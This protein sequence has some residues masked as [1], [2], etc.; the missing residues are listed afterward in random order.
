MSKKIINPYSIQSIEAYYDD[1]S[2]TLKEGAACV[3]DQSKTDLEDGT[4]AIKDVSKDISTVVSS[5]NAFLNDV[6][7]AFKHAD[8]YMSKEIATSTRSGTGI[9]ES[10]SYQMLP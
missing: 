8:D 7:I 5:L 2:T 3:D 1:F 9:R 4:K 6:A 10:D